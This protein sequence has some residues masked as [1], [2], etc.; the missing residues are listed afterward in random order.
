VGVS[1]PD[2][3]TECV[4]ARWDAEHERTVEFYA[5][6][7]GG[8]IMLRVLPDGQVLVTLFRLHEKVRVRVEEGHLEPSDTDTP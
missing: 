3:D 6:A 8:Y 4:L 1:R 7:V 2:I 5:G